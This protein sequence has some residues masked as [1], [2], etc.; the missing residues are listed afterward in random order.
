[1][2]LSLIDQLLVYI[3]IKLLRAK[4]LEYNR[5]NLEAIK[6]IYR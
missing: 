2:Q 6:N 1:M 4:H 5:P 3:F